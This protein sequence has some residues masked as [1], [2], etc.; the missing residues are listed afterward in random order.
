MTK[1][2][3]KRIKNIA[4]LLD[5][6]TLARWFAK[7]LRDMKKKTG[8]SVSLIIIPKKKNWKER[9]SCFKKIFLNGKLMRQ[10][11]LQIFVI[12]LQKILDMES[13]FTQRVPLRKLGI[14]KKSQRVFYQP[15][16]R[17]IYSIAVPE[18]IISLLK[19]KK[20]PVLINR[21]NK[22]IKGKALEALPFG[23]LS[24]HGG[25]LRKYRGARSVFKSY[26]HQ[27]PCVYVT[28]QRI[29]EDLDG[30]KIVFEK[31]L[32][33][34]NARSYKEFKDHLYLGL[35][36]ILSTGIKR[37]NQGFKPYQPKKLGKVYYSPDIL[38]FLVE[39]IEFLKTEIKRKSA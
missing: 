38:G 16:T 20:I 25:N 35:S 31:P 29:T 14:L 17:G 10:K 34:Q 4:L 30:G 19:R 5:K 18:E 36:T 13:V 23:I 9:L 3:K 21:G 24:F 22:I 1:T 28:L 15:I 39:L 26:Y 33:V 7:A 11:I 12:Y 27:E 32:N 37:L 8:V 2:P 6:P